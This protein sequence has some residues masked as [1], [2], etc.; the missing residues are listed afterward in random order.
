MAAKIDKKTGIQQN[1]YSSL[2]EIWGELSKSRTPITK[3]S[4]LAKA[5]ELNAMKRAAGDGGKVGFHDIN[6]LR[7]N[8]L[9][10][11]GFISFGTS[12]LTPDRLLATMNHRFV[13]DPQT[14]TGVLFNYDHYKLGAIKGLD[15][16][17]DIGAKNRFVVL[18]TVNFSMKKGA[19]K[20]LAME[21]QPVG[22]L[23]P[24]LGEGVSRQGVI[25]EA[26]SKKLGDQPP[27]SFRVRH[28]LETAYTPV[29]QGLLSQ[30]QRRRRGG[31]LEN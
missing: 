27:A 31:L 14:G 5:E 24:E 29:M 23:L 20:S 2:H 17:A 30:E 1:A 18:D 13:L 4:L 11:D 19:P 3:D 9:E 15:R 25:R 7:K 21:P 12:A 28:G 8:I 10:Q 26:V 6:S 16:I 22:R